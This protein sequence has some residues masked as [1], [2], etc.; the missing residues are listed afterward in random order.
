[1]T[2]TL[3]NPKTSIIQVAAVN[4]EN[5][6]WDSDGELLTYLRKKMIPFGF[7][8]LQSSQTWYWSMLRWFIV[9]MVTVLNTIPNVN[10]AIG[11]IQSNVIEFMQSMCEV[12]TMVYWSV[13]TA[14]ISYYWKEITQIFVTFQHIWH[15]IHA[16]DLPEWRETV[17]NSQKFIERLSIITFW[18]FL[19]ANVSY[20]IVAICV[21][22][23]RHFLYDPPGEMAYGIHA[24]FVVDTKHDLTLYLSFYFPLT[25]FQFI[26]VQIHAAI[27]LL[28]IFMPYYYALYFK[29]IQLKI[30]KLNE[31]LG[32]ISPREAKKELVNIIEEH[33][34]AIDCV[35]AFEEEIKIVLLTNYIMNTFIICFFMFAF[36][37]LLQDNIVTFIIF[38]GYAAAV[39]TNLV[40]LSYFGQ[41]LLDESDGVG[42][43]AWNMAW[44]DQD[45]EFQKCIKFIIMRSQKPVAVSGAGFYYI[46]LESYYNIQLVRS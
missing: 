46:S 18:L 28:I 21:S 45:M 10:G 15:E 12:S 27:E 7:W 34:I 42:R 9:I 23:I 39:H 3:S 6:H 5:A 4:K 26:F 17:R 43:A 41:F 19:V 16:Y 40:Y 1:M 22:M 31:K 2:R 30:N 33:K 38:V 24:D 25:I 36:I 14:F 29:L 20:E 32:K 37:K 11:L 8:P 13:R 44:Y 35:R